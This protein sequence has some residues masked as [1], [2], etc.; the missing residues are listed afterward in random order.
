[1]RSFYEVFKV[2]KLT[3]S[4][5]VAASVWQEK[6]VVKGKKECCLMGIVSILQDEEI[7]EVAQ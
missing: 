3:E 2:V 4:I 7:L 6:G 5:V 1:M